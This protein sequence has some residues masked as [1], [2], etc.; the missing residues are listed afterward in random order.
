[1]VVNRV[2][3]ELFRTWSHV[4][5][6]RALQDTA[7]GFTGNEIARITQMHPN[8]AFKALTSLENL[9]IVRRQ[10]GGRDHLFTLN[11]NHYLVEQGIIPLFDAEQRFLDEIKSSI[12][13]ALKS[14]AVSVILFGSVALG[15]ENPQSD[16]DLCCI[17]RNRSQQEKAQSALDD[18][19]PMLYNRFGIKIG[20]I[21]FTLVE[22]RKKAAKRNPLIDQILEHGKIITGKNPRGLL[23]D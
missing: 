3:D 6:L 16:L 4:A 20:P 7:T 8:S 11:R 10:R 22:F 5:V 15:E 2:F 23:R 14:K 21:F 17:V 13:N 18:I 12:K 1:M 9:G 19:S